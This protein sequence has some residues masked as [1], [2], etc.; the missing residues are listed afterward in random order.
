MSAGT[1]KQTP[2]INLARIISALKNVKWSDA[3]KIT[4]WMQLVATQKS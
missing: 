4:R 3:I 1:K 2:F